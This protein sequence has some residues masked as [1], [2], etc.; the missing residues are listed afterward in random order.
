LLVRCA[1]LVAKQVRASYWLFSVATLFVP[2]A[3]SVNVSRQN[4]PSLADKAPE[5]G[6]GIV[7]RRAPPA[8]TPSEEKPS[9]ITSAQQKLLDQK[10]ARERRAQVDRATELSDELLTRGLTGVY[11]MSYESLK[12][13]TQ[14]W[15]YQGQDG[16]LYGPYTAQ[17]LASWKAQGVFNSTWV[18]PVGENHAADNSTASASAGVSSLR[19]VAPAD[20]MYDDDIY[21]TE[22]AAPVAPAVVAP[23]EWV[24]SDEVDFGEY[25][26]LDQAHQQLQQRTEQ[27]KRQV[28]TSAQAR[29][30]AA[31]ELR[32]ERD[33]EGNGSGSALTRGATLGDE[34]D[35]EPEEAE[36][37]SYRKRKNTGRRTQ[38]I[39]DDSDEEN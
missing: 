21:S 6:A 33:G 19:A 23:A 36:G 3:Y 7:R 27:R 37:L 1:G 5:K 15:E 12:A 39:P 28:Q 24:N 20:S 29:A 30:A 25:V 38:D 22:P 18:R 32:A 31:A 34:E 11:S 2:S 13:S 35:E 16:Q 9:Q 26:N 17:Q 14:T 4:T 10:Q 8:A